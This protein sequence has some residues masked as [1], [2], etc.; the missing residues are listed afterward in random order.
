MSAL[1]QEVSSAKKIIIRSGEFGK[2]LF[3]ILVATAGLVVLSPVFAM[4][5]VYIRR[6][7]SKS[8]FY[9]GL[10]AGL[11]GNNFRILKFTTMIDSPESEDGPRVTANDDPRVTPGGRWLRD[12]KLNEIP[13]LWN[14]LKGEMSLVGPRPEDPGIVSTWTESERKT[15]LSVRPGITSPA[16]IF[17]RDEEKLLETESVMEK[18]LSNIVPSKIRLDQIYARDHSFLGDLDII[19]LTALALFPGVRTRTIPENVLTWGPLSRIMTRHANYLL[20]DVLIAL[21]SI[22]FSGFLWRVIGPLN[23]GWGRAL[24]LAV[25]IAILFGLVNAMLGMN[26]ISW[27]H[28][29]ASDALG[30]A[31]SGVLTTGVIFTF[32]RFS[33]VNT[34]LPLGMWL[35]TGFLAFSGFTAVRY[36]SR[37]I[38]GLATRWLQWRGPVTRLGERVLIIGAG[39]MAQLA[40]S[41]FR[42]G[43]P[44]KIL[45][46]VGL[47]DDDSKKIGLRFDG[48]KVIGSTM[49]IPQL[50]ERWDVGVILY[51]I[52]NVPLNNAA[53]SSSAAARPR[54]ALC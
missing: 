38:T 42:Q 28:A 44:G 13:Q 50:V 52:G 25:L 37:L 46:I 10:R 33:Q 22:G 30:L 16:S 9:R 39:E 40:A 51:A 11:R 1:D 31:V 36:Q 43:E 20:A 24:L 21:F 12:T 23:L 29:Q 45:N 32:D 53:R 48:N 4:V 3:D 47:V 5:A 27:S 19:F 6:T 34:H 41:F 2:R 17:F 18:Y 35:L 49:D 14:V 26:R 15:I 54:R 8:V 7:Y